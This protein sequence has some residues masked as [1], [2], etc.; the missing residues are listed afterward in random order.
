MNEAKSVT[1]T[2]PA[3]WTV[4]HQSRTDAIREVGDLAGIITTAA[5]AVCGCYM[6]LCDVIRLHG[7]TDDEVRS[8]IGGRFPAPRVS[9]LLRVAN[10]PDETYRRY[11]AGFFGFK[12]ALQECRG[13][14]ILPERRLVQ[15]RIRRAAERLVR[16]AGPGVS[17]RVGRFSIAI[18]ADAA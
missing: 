9:E 10:A 16:L 7:L 18:Q 17:V 6:R 15:K 8:A 4:S 13:Y 2:V 1:V 12:A 14:R 11:R 3:R 5:D